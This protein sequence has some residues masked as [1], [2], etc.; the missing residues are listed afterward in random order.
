MTIKRRIF[1]SNILMIVLTLAIGAAVFFTTRFIIVDEDTTTRGGIGGRFI[2]S[3][4]IPVLGASNANQAFET[5]GFTYLGNVSLYHSGLGDFIIV[6][7]DNYLEA[8]EDFVSTPGFVIPIIIVYLIIVAVLGNVLLAKY[9]THRIMSPINTLADGVHE[10]SNG[11]LTHRIQYK[12]GDEFDA[13]CS[14]FNEMAARLYE[15]VEQRQADENSRKE[16]IAGISHDLRTPLT[17]VKAYLE[18]LRKGIATTPEMQE[19]YLNIIQ[20]KTDDIEYIIKQLFMFS[21]IDIGEFPL[22]LEVVD[23]GELLPSIVRGFAEEYKGMG[24]TVSLEE[25]VNANVLID[26]VQFKNIIQNILGNS[27]KYSNSS[28]ACAKI[29]CSV[30]DATIA[31][32]IEDNGPGVPHEM[33]TKMFDVF[34]RGDESRNNPAKGSGLGLAISSKIIQRFDGAIWAQNIAG[35]G[36]GVVIN[37]PRYSMER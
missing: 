28:N 3:P 16:L 7:P 26:T 9:I 36:L 5:G 31:I 34:Y 13:V 10:I 17:S 2:D 24:L 1:L 6:V 21:K 4:H 35:G 19:K 15:M 11:N 14:N 37:L 29:F 32:R 8:I 30:A 23:I 27:L 20:K 12:G 22:N 18:G 33:L 25:S